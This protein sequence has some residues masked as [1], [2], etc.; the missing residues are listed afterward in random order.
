MNGTCSIV[1]SRVPTSR[2]ESRKG[3][4]PAAMASIPLLPAPSN[5]VYCGHRHR[6]P[7]S[8]GDDIHHRSGVSKDARNCGQVKARASA[9]ITQIEARTAENQSAHQRRAKMLRQPRIMANP[10]RPPFWAGDRSPYGVGEFGP[11]AR[12]VPI[13]TKSAGRQQRRYQPLVNTMTRYSDPW[14][15]PLI[16]KTERKP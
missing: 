12:C 16:R 4:D 3:R 10:A 2:L 14:C 5:P 1:F 13:S 9:R 15:Y 11:L 6:V 8:G 7:E